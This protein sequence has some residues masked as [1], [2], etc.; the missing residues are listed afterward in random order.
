MI[1]SE[2]PTH[3]AVRDFVTALDAQEQAAF[4]AAVTRDFSFTSEERQADAGV[5]PA[6]RAAIVINDQDAD[7]LTLTG[8][9]LRRDHAEPVQWA[10]SARDGKIAELAVTDDADV[11]ADFWFEAMAELERRLDGSATPGSATLVG[12]GRSA[13]PRGMLRRESLGDRRYVMRWGPGA[14]GG[15]DWINTGQRADDDVHRS[16]RSPSS[17]DH[18]DRGV[19]ICD[20]SSV[21]SHFEL[22]LGWDGKGY[23]KATA[24]YWAKPYYWDAVAW[25]KERMSLSG[26]SIPNITGT[27]TLTGPDG[28]VTS[29]EDITI[30]GG[31][32]PYE[33]IFD[34]E[35]AFADMPTGTYTLTFTKAVKDGGTWFNKGRGKVRLKDHTITFTVGG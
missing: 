13:H 24:L 34:R 21:S 14:L 33:R 35:L 27:L 5:F 15:V 16:F 20:V 18:D 11:P 8:V 1:I 25:C 17:G 28:A 6:T 23:Q 32:K 3:P 29:T 22:K 10:F 9:V 30:T 31:R 2:K 12:P 4:E 7:G 26:T 19:G